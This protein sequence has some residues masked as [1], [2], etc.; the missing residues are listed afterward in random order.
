MTKTGGGDVPAKVVWCGFFFLDLSKFFRRE[1][2]VFEELNICVDFRF[3]PL[4]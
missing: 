4:F 1:S 2:C 3:G